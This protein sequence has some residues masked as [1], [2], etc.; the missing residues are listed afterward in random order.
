MHALTY[1]YRARHRAGS[2]GYRILFELLEL[3]LP[4]VWRFRTLTRD[5]IVNGEARDYLRGS[6]CCLR[7]RHF[8]C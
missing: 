4:P 7:R 8:R 5:V 2:G 3:R 1:C 6:S